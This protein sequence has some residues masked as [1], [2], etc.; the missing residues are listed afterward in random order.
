MKVDFIRLFRRT[1]GP[2]EGFE[3]LIDAVAEL[4][5]EIPEIKLTIVG[6][7]PEE[8]NQNQKLKIKN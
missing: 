1:A 6:S 3:V 7:G 4:K 5:T 2:M 8:E